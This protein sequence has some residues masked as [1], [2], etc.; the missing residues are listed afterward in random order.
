MLKM[1]LL[2]GGLP[3]AKLMNPSHAIT[4]SIPEAAGVQLLCLVTTVTTV[5]FPSCFGVLA[6]RGLLPHL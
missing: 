2:L 5:T 6:Y 4:A 1:L 3:A